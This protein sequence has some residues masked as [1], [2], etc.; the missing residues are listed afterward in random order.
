M[1]GKLIPTAKLADQFNPTLIAEA[2]GLLD[3]VNN[4]AVNT[5]ANGPVMK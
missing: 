4:S 2:I 5:H 1:K 3:W